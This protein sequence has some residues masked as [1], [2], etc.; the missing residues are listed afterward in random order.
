MQNEGLSQLWW[1]AE[2]MLHWGCLGRIFRGLTARI[3]GRIRWR[4]RVPWQVDLLRTVLA[5]FG[6]REGGGGTLQSGFL[7]RALAFSARWCATPRTRAGLYYTTGWM[8]KEN[9]ERQEHVC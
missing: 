9:G 4:V 8:G 6:E 7:K 2:E 5:L 3:R 1:S